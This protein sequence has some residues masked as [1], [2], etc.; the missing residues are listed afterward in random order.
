MARHVVAPLNEIAEGAQKPVIVGNRPITVFRVNG[1]NAALDSRCPHAGCSL[2]AGKLTGR[3]TS[4]E[5][6][7]LPATTFPVETDETDV[8]VEP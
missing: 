5:A 6:S 4:A 8:V 1:D 2:A 7:A 3:V